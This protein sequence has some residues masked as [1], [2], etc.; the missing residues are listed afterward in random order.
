MMNVFEDCPPGAM[1][2]FATEHGDWLGGYRFGGRS[3][4]SPNR[5]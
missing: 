1:G 4:R 2:L 3:R 5:R